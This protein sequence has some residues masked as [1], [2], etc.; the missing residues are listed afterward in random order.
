MMIY[1]TIV[2][3]FSVAVAQLF[4]RYYPLS[5]IW[6]MILECAGYVCWGT[7]LGSLGSKV[8]SMQG[9]DSAELLDQKLSSLFSILGIF[10][11]TVARAL[12]PL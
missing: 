2:V 8:L 7:T 11:F 1:S 4:N 3:L 10:T 6:V 5:E 12:D 9:Q